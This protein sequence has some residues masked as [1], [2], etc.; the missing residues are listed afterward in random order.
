MAR[1]GFDVSELNAWQN[2]LEQARREFPETVLRPLA[3]W[4]GENFGAIATSRYMRDVGPN[5][6]SD[7]RSRDDDTLESRTGQ[8]ARALAGRRGRIQGA[9]GAPLHDTSLRLTNDGAV[10]ERV[11]NLVYARVQEEGAR[12]PVTE[13]MKSYF[14]YRSYKAREEGREGDAE[15]WTRMALT[16]KSHFRIPPRPVIEPTLNDIEAPAEREAQRLM[17]DLLQQLTS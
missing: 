1:T 8:Y 2:E 16:S 4:F 14:W 15:I 3:K 13:K 7:F 12:V 10:W 11:I 17:T 6:S 5:P 9:G